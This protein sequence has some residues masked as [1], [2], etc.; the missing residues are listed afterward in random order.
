MVPE[1]ALSSLSLALDSSFNIVTLVAHEGGVTASPPRSSIRMV[2]PNLKVLSA[3]MTS[4]SCEVRV[5]RSW[6][7][8]RKLADGIK[9]GI[10]S[11]VALQ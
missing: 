3:I 9:S 7:L 6:E 2:F 5:S 11:Q 10:Q 1:D 8:N 4:K